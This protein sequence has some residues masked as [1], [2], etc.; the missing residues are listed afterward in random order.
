MALASNGQF[1]LLSLEET[2]KFLN[3]I[4]GGHDGTFGGGIVDHR[5]IREGMQ[6]VP[7][8]PFRLRLAD[9][10][11]FLVRHPDFVSIGVAG[12][13]VVH[14]DPERDNSTTILEPLLIMSIEY[15][16]PVSLSDATNGASA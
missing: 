14:V 9:G 4:R 12:R 13:W 8:R 7:F 1:A 10:L 2:I 6:A 16:P 15:P 11:E 5:V 3:P